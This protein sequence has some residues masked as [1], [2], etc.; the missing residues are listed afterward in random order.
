MTTSQRE[1]NGARRELPAAL[2][3]RRS[4]DARGAGRSQAAIAGAAVDRPGISLADRG[5]QRG[6][7]RRG[8]RWRSRRRSAVTC[9][10]ACSRTRGRGF[11]ITPG[12]DERG[13]AR[14]S[15]S[16]MA[17]RPEV[18]VYRP[19]RG[20][21]DLVLVDPIAHDASRRSPEPASARRA[22]G[23]LVRAEDGCAARRL[24]PDATA[25]ASDGCSS[26]AT[27]RRCARSSAR[28]RNARR[29]V[30]GPRRRRIRSLTGGAAVARCGDR[31][32]RTSERGQRDDPRW[33]APRDHRRAIASWR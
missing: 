20:V 27:P 22:A 21:I 3:R 12:R 2:G 24:A 8:P 11:A 5:G 14:D 31:L 7:E 6:A 13:A 29:R 1:L 23:P 30:P 26:C 19:V 4:T 25:N 32:G 9:R 10:S 16:A 17:A 33:A 15:P 18:P 28:R